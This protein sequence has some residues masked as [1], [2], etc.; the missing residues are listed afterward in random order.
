MS[1]QHSLEPHIDYID[2]DEYSD[3]GHRMAS[4]LKVTSER[5]DPLRWIIVDLAAQV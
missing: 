3:D 5:S 4:V 1:R 2:Y